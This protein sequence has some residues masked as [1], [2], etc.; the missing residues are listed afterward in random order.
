VVSERWRL[1]LTMQIAKTKHASSPCAPA[2]VS[3]TARPL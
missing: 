3:V 2:G 1:V